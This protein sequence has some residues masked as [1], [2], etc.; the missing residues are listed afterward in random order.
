MPTSIGFNL[1][2][3]STLLY[4]LLLPVRQRRNY[5]ASERASVNAIVAQ[6]TSSVGLVWFGRRRR[7]DGSII[8][9]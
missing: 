6:R 4:S 8:E 2:R 7:V 5:T 3:Y 9:Q 1:P